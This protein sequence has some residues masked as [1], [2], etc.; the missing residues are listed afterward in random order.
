MIEYPISQLD[1]FWVHISKPVY[2]ISAL[3][4]PLLD[5][6]RVFIIRAV[7]GQ[8]P[9]NADRNHIHHKLLDCNYGH[10]KTVIII[11][12]FSVVTIGGSILTYFFNAPTYGLITVVGIGALFLLVVININKR[13]AK[14]KEEPLSN[15]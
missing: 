3:A 15:E 12:F 10:V 4:Y 5:T 13:K 2:A 6:L 8:S 14:R 7:K 11:Y 9:F 1:E